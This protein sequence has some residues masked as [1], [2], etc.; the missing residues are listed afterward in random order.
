MI[1]NKK[2]L[3]EI[4]GKTPQHVDKLQEKGLPHT[5]GGKGKPNQY[6]TAEVIDWLVRG[7]NVDYQ[8]ERARLTKNQADIE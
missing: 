8:K 2:K 4:I 3:C 6:D 5:K 7:E 1:V